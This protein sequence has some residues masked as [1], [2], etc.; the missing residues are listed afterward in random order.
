MNVQR[1]CFTIHGKLKF[2]IN[3]MVDS[4][5]LLKYVIDPD[6]VTQM[7]KDLRIFGIT[8]TSVFPDLDSLSKDLVDFFR[9]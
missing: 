6:A 4:S 3:H 8:N 2:S 7:K 5:L 1:S 9:D